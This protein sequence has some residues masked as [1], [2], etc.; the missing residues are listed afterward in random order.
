MQTRVYNRLIKRLTKT[1]DESEFTALHSKATQMRK[2]AI[3]K[4]AKNK[5]HPAD[6]LKSSFDPDSFMAGISKTS[7]EIAKN[8]GK[9]KAGKKAL[10]KYKEFIGIPVPCE[11]K[12]RLRKKTSGE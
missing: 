8:V 3:R 4:K 6:A 5:S 11:F 2:K 10:A 9:T 7:L 1:D 12:K